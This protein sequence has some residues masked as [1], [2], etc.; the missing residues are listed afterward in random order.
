MGWRR[1]RGAGFKHSP[2]PQQFRTM[3][4]TIKIKKRHN[5]LAEVRSYVFDAVKEREQGI[6]FLFVNDVGRI[7]QTMTIPHGELSRGFIT[8][9]GIKSKMVR[10]QV[11]DLVSFKWED[12][13]DRLLR[14]SAEKQMSIFDIVYPKT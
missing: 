12:D 10:G 13:K 8:A 11:F 1:F 2:P 5:G 6:K 7:V 9:R 4:K 14:E 3:Y